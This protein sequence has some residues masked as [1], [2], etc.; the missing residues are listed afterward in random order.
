[1]TLTHTRGAR[2]ARAMNLAELLVSLA[3]LG[4]VLTG[5]LSALDQGRRVWT[6]GVARVEAQ[7]SARVALE[8]VAYDVRRAGFGSAEFAA[9]SV[10][11]RARLVLQVDQD[12]NGVISGVG[13]TITWRLAGTIL[14]RDAG[15]GAQ[16]IV[17]G[18]RAFTLRYL[19]GRGAETAHPLDVRA[20]IVEL[21]VDADHA[22]S[23]AGAPVSMSTRVRLRNR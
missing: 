2:D 18:V 20:L 13:E 22:P 21:T 11:E 3:L 15:G 14:R 16:P 1:M 4:L 10:A 8:R 12:G 9:I 5:A 6:F 17:N 23:R 7:Q 19:D